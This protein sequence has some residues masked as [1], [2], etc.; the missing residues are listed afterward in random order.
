MIVIPKESTPEIKI[1]IIGVT[2]AYPGSSSFDV[3]RLLTDPIENQLLRS[4][5][6]VDSITS[7]SREGVSSVVVN[8]ESSVDIDEALG[9]VQNEV[10]KIVNDLPSDSIDP[11]VEAFSFEDQPVFIA[12]LSSTE[13]FTQLT[14]TVDRVEDLFLDVSGVSRVEISGIPDRQITVIL[15][16]SQLSQYGISAST[17][18][19]SIDQADFSIPSGSF[20]QEGVEYSITIDN[21]LSD[22]ISIENVIVTTGVSGEYVYVKD[23]ARI[24]DGLAR[25]TSLSRLSV[26]GGESQ[27]AITFFVY[28]KVGGDVTS[29]TKELRENLKMIQ[30]EL[31]GSDF[32]TLIDSGNDVSSDIRD[33]SKSALQTIILVIVILSIGLG[34]R[35]SLIAG[36]AIP[37]SFLLAFIGLYYS[38]N[39]INFISLFSLILSI[40]LLVDSSIVIIEGISLWSK[41]GLSPDAAIRATLKEFGG[42]VISGT[43]TTLVVFI[44]LMGLSGVTG[45]FIRVI[46]LTIIFV[47][48]ASLVVALIF[49]P[50]LST[51]SFGGVKNSRYVQRLSSW[52]VEKFAQAISFYKKI[53]TKLLSTKKY[54]KRLIWGLVVMFFASLTLVGTGLIK[55]EFFPADQFTQLTITA[56]LPRGSLLSDMDTAILGVEEHLRGMNAVESF[57]SQIRSNDSDITV[58]LRS[59][60]GGDQVLADIRSFLAQQ[61]ANVSFFASPPSSGPSSEAPVS[62]ELT[63]SNYDEVLAASI[64]IKNVLDTVGG[65]IDVQS[66]VSENV[67]G[68]VVTLD[69]KKIISAGLDPRG[70][71][72]MIRTSLFGTEATEIKR[73]DD[74]VPVIVKTGVN[75]SYTSSDTTYHISID[76]LR[77]LPVQTRNGNVPLGSFISETVRGNTPVIN[78]DDGDRVVNVSAA[79][80]VDANLSVVIA[81]F[82]DKM[83]EINFPESVSWSATGDA[84]ESAESG[85][86]LLIAMFV[87]VLLV[88]GVLIFQFNSVK[89]M[90]F[91][92]SVIPLGLIGVLFG[93]F[94]FNQTLSFTAMLG[95]VALIGI[96]VNNSIILI[97]V[98]STLAEEK[99]LSH[100]EVVIE[101]A[102]ARL[103]PIL[104]TTATTVMGMFPLLLTSPVWRPLALAIISGLIFAV[105][106]T[107]FLIP[108][109]FYKW[110][111]E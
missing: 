6:D 57:V 29:V 97:D 39:T 84:E 12:S 7:S 103:R 87:G 53:L 1:P 15:D 8:F 69:T 66:S 18:Y 16:K 54:G 51:L 96:V 67:L 88:I 78:H 50:L 79:L 28:K 107:L 30:E 37:M 44:P 72:G 9:D 92:V 40:G 106:L 25:Y 33:L 100:K 20:V 47:L 94:F 74:D 27:Q 31:P 42:S 35:E 90:A 17:V 64:E 81:E 71:A 52:R 38:G 32:I 43:M 5:K 58:I 108:L 91:I 61:S 3:E 89:K 2:T 65:A 4:L 85:I 62:I 26:D 46:P 14:E 19:Q 76:E 56:E 59:E 55:S 11:L 95:F 22:I 45:Q 24:E 83:E 77:A 111:G 82:T 98:L 109:M 93:L 73:G 68:V 41:K 102:S 75:D 110:G 21:T 104:L 99:K 80:D 101:G 63:G 70:L 48:L 86:Q 34:I 23:V 105:I 49:V 60:K 13:A 36:I 10:D